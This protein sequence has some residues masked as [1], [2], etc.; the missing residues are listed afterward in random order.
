[1]S[2]GNT[3]I[4]AFLIVKEMEF[5]PGFPRTE[6]GV[7]AYAKQVFMIAGDREKFR[8]LADVV[9]R[10]AERLPTPIEIRRIMSSQ[11]GKPADGLES[12][13]VDLAD[14]MGR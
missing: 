10:G 3:P 9:L 12:R 11:V 6:E 2:E 4:W 7:K 8:K 13:E 5:L 1:M 14:L